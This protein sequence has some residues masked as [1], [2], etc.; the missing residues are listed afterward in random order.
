[1]AFAFCFWKPFIQSCTYADC[2]FANFDG[3]TVASFTSG[4]SSS[5]VNCTF[6][7][8][9]L[10]SSIE[11]TAVVLAKADD[12]TAGDTRVR[13]QGCS[14]TGNTPETI[15]TLLADSRVQSADAVF[16]GDSASTG[17]PS[18]ISQ[19]DGEDDCDTGN[20]RGLQYS[21]D[22]FLSANNCWLVDV[23]KVRP[24]NLF[25][26]VHAYVVD[27]YLKTAADSSLQHAVFIACACMASSRC[28]HRFTSL[29]FHFYLVPL[30]RTLRIHS[31][32]CTLFS[33]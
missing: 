28:D 20:V 25:E 11:G 33:S 13:L 18:C 10:H 32:H 24:S 14:F 23:Q 9:T 26:L 17:I 1:M 15:P 29:F 30:I 16:Y 8:N 12:D 27:I 6:A 3:G 19:E 31:C 22:E 7:D 2:T 21:G 5:L 4:S